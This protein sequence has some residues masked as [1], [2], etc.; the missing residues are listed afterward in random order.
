MIVEVL[1]WLLPQPEFL[2]MRKPYG[3]VSMREGDRGRE[4]ER[5]NLTLTRGCNNTLKTHLKVALE[6]VKSE[7]L[8]SHDPHNSLGCRL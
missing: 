6:V 7:P 2:L 5:L 3:F 1:V 8:D 4:R